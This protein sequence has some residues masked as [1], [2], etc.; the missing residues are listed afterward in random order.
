MTLAMRILAWLWPFPWTL[1]GGALGCLALPT[2]S[3]LG[4]REGVLHF[5]GG[6][7]ANWLRQ[8][9]VAGGAAAMTL[10]HV[11]LAADSKLLQSC[12]QHELVHVRQYERWGPFLVPAYLACT[13]VLWLQGRDPYLENPFER[14]A[15]AH[16]GLLGPDLDR[17]GFPRDVR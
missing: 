9:P 10:G 6:A 13:T 17:P 14:E 1:V 3:R 16:D 7:L 2:G 12:W 8:L 5:S 15:F 11:V 4:Q